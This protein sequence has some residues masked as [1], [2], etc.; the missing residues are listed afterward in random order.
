MTEPLLPIDDYQAFAAGSE[1]DETRLAG[2]VGA[3]RDYCGWHIAPAVDETFTV[4]SEG[5][6]VL[7]LRT[8]RLNSVTSVTENGTAV[9]EFEWSQ[10][11]SLRRECWTDRYRGVVV[12]ANHGYDIIP[13]SLKTVVLDAVSRA[14]S[15]PAGQQPE[16]IGPFEYGGSQGGV[17]FFA[18]ETAVLDRYRLESLG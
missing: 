16:K 3:I 7:Q 9:T 11:G 14:V 12:V 4:D 1:V 10:D 6:R 18:H 13:D 17:Q 5:G 8:L 15:V 2:V